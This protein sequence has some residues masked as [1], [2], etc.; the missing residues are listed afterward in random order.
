MYAC[1]CIYI[2]MWN[3]INLCAHLCVCVFV[4][5]QTWIYVHIY[6]HTNAYADTDTA[7]RTYHSADMNESCQSC[8]WVTSPT[9]VRR[10][11]ASTQC[12]YGNKY[13]H[14]YIYTYAHKHAHID[15][16]LTPSRSLYTCM[17]IY[18]Y[19]FTHVQRRSQ[20]QT[21]TVLPP[22]IYMILVYAHIYFCFFRIFLIWEKTDINK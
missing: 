8:E 10:H 6:W 7:Y 9:W 14:I 12:T 5:I 18:V 16:A 15:L 11:A 13:V 4:Y 20:K 17:D 2:S 1:V 3:D 19:I 22:F 21:P